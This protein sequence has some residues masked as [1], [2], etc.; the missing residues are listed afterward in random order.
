MENC[1]LV[2]YLT[3]LMALLDIKAT[4]QLPE[5]T[6]PPLPPPERKDAKNRDFRPPSG[7]HVCCDGNSD[8]LG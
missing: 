6:S 8:G 1:L 7:R 2:G 5:E 3:R 4:P